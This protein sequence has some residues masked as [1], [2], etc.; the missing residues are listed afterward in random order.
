MF[1][2]ATRDIRQT[3]EN[4]HKKRAQTWTPQKDNNVGMER[5]SYSQTSTFYC[6]QQYAVDVDLT[7]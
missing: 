7:A 5:E 1:V 6:E 2:T 4:I 3:S